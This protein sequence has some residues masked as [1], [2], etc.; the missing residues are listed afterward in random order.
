MGA[1]YLIRLASTSFSGRALQA[2]AAQDGWH[3]TQSSA[4]G[5][6]VTTDA[7]APRFAV[8]KP[9]PD[10]MFL[11]MTANGLYGDYAVDP[12]TRQIE[13]LS[14]QCVEVHERTCRVW[15]IC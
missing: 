1:A 9:G 4:T 12:Y 8:G 15:K 11:D 2:L 10:K 3:P 5:S 6:D 14:M 13:I 7:H